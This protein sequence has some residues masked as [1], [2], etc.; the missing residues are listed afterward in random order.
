M[1]KASHAATEADWS[2]IDPDGRLF[3]YTADDWKRMVY[4]Y[5]DENK[6][7]HPRYE[8]FERYA[9]AVPETALLE[10]PRPKKAAASRAAASFAEPAPRM[11]DDPGVGDEDD[12]DG[13]TA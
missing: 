5:G 10:A 1:T 7:T 4:A 9:E 8:R 11:P 3:A 13:A 6:L 12:E 2:D